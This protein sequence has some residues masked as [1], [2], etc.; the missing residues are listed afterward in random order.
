MTHGSLT[1]TDEE[2]RKRDKK[3]N[4]VSGWAAV[5]YIQGIILDDKLNVVA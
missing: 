5:Q 1:N 2:Y 4:E 3:K